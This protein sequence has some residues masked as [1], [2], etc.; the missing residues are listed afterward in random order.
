MD[1]WPRSSRLC[2][3]PIYDRCAGG[4]YGYLDSTPFVSEIIAVGLPPVILKFIPRLIGMIGLLLVLWALVP[5]KR[6]T[7]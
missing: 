5:G 2:G 1:R 3:H 7:D 6:R 4:Q